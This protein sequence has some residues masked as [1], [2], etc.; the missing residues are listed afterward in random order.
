MTDDGGIYFLKVF[1]PVTAPVT[2]IVFLLLNFDENL[3]GGHQ[4]TAFKKR[5]KMIVPD[6]NKHV[7]LINFMPWIN[8]RPCVY[9]ISGLRRLHAI[10][11]S[12]SHARSH[13]GNLISF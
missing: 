1:L 8:Q 2:K 7:G 11:P 3:T 9:A 5:R 4:S 13:Q 6:R 12:L 10:R